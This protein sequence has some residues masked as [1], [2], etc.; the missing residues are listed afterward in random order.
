M[1]LS[2]GSQQWMIPDMIIQDRSKTHKSTNVAKNRS[3]RFFVLGSSIKKSDGILDASCDASLPLGKDQ[4]RFQFFYYHG[5]G[6]EVT[7]IFF[8]NFV[9][10]MTRGH[11]NWVY[12]CAFTSGGLSGIIQ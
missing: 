5:S 10:F 2:W 7:S 1:Q 4:T 11:K 6:G 3:R 8:E 9:Y 12:V